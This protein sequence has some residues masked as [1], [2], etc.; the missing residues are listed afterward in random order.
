MAERS[1]AGRKADMVRDSM[2]ALDH[3]VP[4][5]GDVD[6]VSPSSRVTGS[7]TNASGTQ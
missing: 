1:I 3:E 6:L 7:Q 5:V 4:C 2:P